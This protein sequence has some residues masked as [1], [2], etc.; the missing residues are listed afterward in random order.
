MRS[1]TGIRRVDINNLL[2]LAEVLVLAAALPL[3]VIA[4][5]GF[6]DAPF[7]RFIKP[8]PVVILSYLIIDSS[9]VV[10]FGL[11]LYVYGAISSVA[12]VSAVYAAVQAAVLLTERRDV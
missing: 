6:R 8:L 2:V 1:K 11:P 5:L 12:V 9:R 10:E 7:G 4:A 3:S